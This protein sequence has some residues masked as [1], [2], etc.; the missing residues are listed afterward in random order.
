[1]IQKVISFIIIIKTI[2]LIITIHYDIDKKKRITSAKKKSIKKSTTNEE[3]NN[4]NHNNN[5]HNH[6]N[7]K[8]EPGEPYKISIPFIRPNN[9]PRI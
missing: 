1:M 7:N 8:F 4:N 2:F 9:L 3:F 6:N 5:N